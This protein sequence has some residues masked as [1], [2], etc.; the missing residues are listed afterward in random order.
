MNIILGGG[1]SGLSSVYEL[2]NHKIN[3][4]VLEKNPSWGGLLYNFSI[5]GFRF[6]KF[7]HLSFAKENY[8]NDIFLQNTIFKTYPFIKNSSLLKKENEI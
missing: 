5:D 3:S 8:V 1:I 4:I 6:D 2:K 7:I